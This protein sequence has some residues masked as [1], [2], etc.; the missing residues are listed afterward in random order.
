MVKVLFNN[1]VAGLISGVAVIGDGDMV[2]GDFEGDEVALVLVLA[3]LRSIVEST[4][5]VRED[6]DGGENTAELPLISS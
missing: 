4:I 5:A 1:T 2:E 3:V 6:D